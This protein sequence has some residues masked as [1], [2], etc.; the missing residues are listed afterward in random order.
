MR[1]NCKSYTSQLSIKNLSHPKVSMYFYLS[2]NI[3]YSSLIMSPRV[4]V[5]IDRLG[6]YN[7]ISGEGSYRSNYPVGN[8]IYIY[9]DTYRI[10]PAETRYYIM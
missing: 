9:A 2:Y 4:R 5:S 10:C 8:V 3:R 7:C 6:L 1:V